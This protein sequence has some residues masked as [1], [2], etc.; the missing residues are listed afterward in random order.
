MT[1]FKIICPDCSAVIVTAY[2]ESMIW[3]LC[4]HCRHHIIDNFDALMSHAVV[5]VNYQ[6][7]SRGA[8]IGN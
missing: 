7:V 2:P 3:E 5:P 8:F 4:P 1:K 6:G